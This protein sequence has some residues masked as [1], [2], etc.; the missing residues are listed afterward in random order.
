MELAEAAL[1]H[2]DY[3]VQSHFRVP[4]VDKSMLNGLIDRK[5]VVARLSYSLCTPF[6]SHSENGLKKLTG[7]AKATCESSAGMRHKTRCLSYGELQSKST[8][9]VMAILVGHCGAY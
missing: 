9:Y 8:M 1:L 7:T 6:F 3:D 5:L 4:R 2:P